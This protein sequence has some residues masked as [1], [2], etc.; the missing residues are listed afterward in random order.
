[1]K[2][3]TSRPGSF[4]LFGIKL[5][6]T[7]SAIPLSIGVS[8]EKQAR[9]IASARCELSTMIQTTLQGKIAAELA[10]HRDARIHAWRQADRFGRCRGDSDE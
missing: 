2:S 7:G 8:C 5:F 1:M 9:T 10:H 4:E 3:A 6:S